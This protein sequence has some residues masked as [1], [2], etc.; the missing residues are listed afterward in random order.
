[1]CPVYVSEFG[2]SA[3]LYCLNHCFVIFG[4]NEFHLRAMFL[5]KIEVLN[6]LQPEGPKS[7]HLAEEFSVPPRWGPWCRRTVES[8]RTLARLI[9]RL[10]WLRIQLY[11]PIFLFARLSSPPV[12]TEQ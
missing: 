1:M 6:M 9:E 4:D 3:L 2:G 5:S 12:L 7:T 8:T 11:I 10:S